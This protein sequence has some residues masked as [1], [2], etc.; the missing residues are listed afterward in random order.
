MPS[1]LINYKKDKKDIVLESLSQLK[2]FMT[3]ESKILNIFRFQTEVSQNI[4]AEIDGVV[5]VSVED[6]FKRRV[7]DDVQSN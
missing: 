4:V 7:L 1:L 6:S 3:Y 5:A 2:G